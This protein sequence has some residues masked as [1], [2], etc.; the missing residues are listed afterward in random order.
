MCLVGSLAEAAMVA[1]LLASSRIA[2]ISGLVLQVRYHIS[3]RLEYRDV[4]ELSWRP[5]AARASKLTCE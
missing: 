5:A 1:A 3:Q 2:L 4:Q